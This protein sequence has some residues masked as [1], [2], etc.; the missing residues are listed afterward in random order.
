MAIA[1]WPSNVKVEAVD[2]LAVEVSGF[3]KRYGSSVAV[4]G[5]DF[6]VQRG[7]I[8]GLLGPNGAGKTTTLE[9]LEGLRAPDAGTLRVMGIDPTRDARRLRNLIGVQLQTAGLPE[10]ITVDEAMRFFCAYH[11][12][13]PRADLFDRVGLADKRRSECRTLST[14]QQRRLALALAVAHDPPVVILD[15][16]TAGLD[17]G[18]RVALHTLMDEMRRRGTTFLLATHDMAEAEKMADRVAVLLKGRVVAT[19]TP[20][21]LT[22]AGSGLTRISV[23]TERDSLRR[24]LDGVPGVARAGWDEEYAVYFSRDPGPTVAAVIALVSARGDALVDMRV[25]RPSLEERF[26]ELTEGAHAS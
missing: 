22:A 25:E 4:D 15:E 13:A 3:R 7:E 17:V 14:G 18:S 1:E 12:V 10:S 19:G 16:P 24:G 21:E 23:R 20:R 8:F 5:I 2:E 26:L 11:G 6:Q 9:C